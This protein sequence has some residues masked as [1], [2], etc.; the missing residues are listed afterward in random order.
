VVLLKQLI[1]LV[2]ELVGFVDGG[3]RLE[4]TDQWKGQQ[5]GIRCH[6]AFL[7]QRHRHGMTAGH[8]AARAPGQHARRE[9]SPLDG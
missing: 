5:T 4:K 1:A 3:T 6:L 7:D 9:L 2:L 8:K